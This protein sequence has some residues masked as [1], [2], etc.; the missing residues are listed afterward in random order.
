MKLRIQEYDEDPSQ[1]EANDYRFEYT[2]SS[3]DPSPT[4]S[5]TTRRSISFLQGPKVVLKQLFLPINYPNSV[6]PSYIWY[7]WYDS[8]QG[9]CS[10]LRGVVSTS[11]VLQAAGVGN[12]EATA[13]SA[14]MAW[15]FRD[16]IGMVGGL[17]FS[18]FCSDTFDSHVKEFR[19]FADV[20]NDVGL[21]LDMVAP[22]FSRP[23]YI[24][25]L[26]TI[27]KTMCGMSAGATKGRITQHFAKHGNMAD[28]TAKES[29]QETLV[30]LL[31]MI[32]GI[33]L[34]R[35]LNG[36]ENKHH[37]EGITW[38]VFVVLTAVH[39][40]ANYRGVVLLKLTSLNPER[41]RV[42]LETCQI[43]ECLVLGED[44]ENIQKALE[45]IPTPEE[46]NE[47]LWSSVTHLA[48][49]TSTVELGG[50]FCPEHYDLLSEFM[51]ERYA[52]GR[53]PNGKLCIS[54]CVGAAIK[55]EL[56]AFLH[57]LV[58]YQRLE[59]GDKWNVDLVQRYV[60]WRSP[61]W[62]TTTA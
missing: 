12:S 51:E 29:T 52:I 45:K 18:Y 17:V 44:I 27:C 46:I 3:N 41:S 53:K 57:A 36:L 5:V 20:I 23:M 55:D 34:A 24:L 33:L 60:M 32:F 50:R 8:L 9:L 43:I 14:A 2:Y 25:S 16:G 56:Q 38:A 47:S 40:W 15:A 30:S 28:L 39:V 54:L 59:K 37:Q 19:L 42:V 58:L 13:I 31:G 11:A 49:P 48:Y 21:T 62:E 7:Q 1:Q 10:Y 6:D 61:A 22:Y 4:T 26:S 35:V